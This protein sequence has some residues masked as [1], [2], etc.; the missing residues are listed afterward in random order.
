MQTNI[1]RADDYDQ[2]C[3]AGNTRTTIPIVDDTTAR[4]TI[5]SL[6]EPDVIFAAART[7]RRYPNLMREGS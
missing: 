2:P 3:A 7:R 1:V 5:V 6:I 4:L